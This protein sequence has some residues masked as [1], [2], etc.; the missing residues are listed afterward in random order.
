MRLN[1]L[2][3]PNEDR[4]STRS[5]CF[6]I[7]N[8][9]AQREI[10]ISPTSHDLS[11][12]IKPAELPSCSNN[13]VQRERHINI[14]QV[15]A[16]KGKTNLSVN[17]TRAGHKYQTTF[18]AEPFYTASALP[19]IRR[20]VDSQL[21]VKINSSQKV[22]NSA[23]RSYLGLDKSSNSYETQ[24]RDVNKLCIARAVKY[25]GRCLEDNGK[26]QKRGQAEITCL[27][28]NR[29]TNKTV[30]FNDFVKS[31]G[32]TKITAKRAGLESLKR[33]TKIQ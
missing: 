1:H 28:N 11:A 18:Q 2:R 16:D 29:K 5:R 8:S 25:K 23:Y 32:E 9:V 33:F 15:Y 7:F 4:L 14:K 10:G 17:N 30:S 31:A 26:G 13:P 12:R 6:P 24:E 27:N 3:M 19:D 21:N 22:Y 20:K